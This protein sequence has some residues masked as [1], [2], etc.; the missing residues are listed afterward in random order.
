MP[1]PQETSGWVPCS[2]EETHWILGIKERWLTLHKVIQ[3]EIQSTQP[4]KYIPLPT[5]PERSPFWKCSRQQ[6]W[7]ED[8]P[9]RRCCR[10]RTCCLQLCPEAEREAFKLPHPTHI[11]GF[12]IKTSSAS[13]PARMLCLC[14]HW[15]VG[16]VCLSAGLHKNYKTDFQETWWRNGTRKEPMKSQCGSGTFFFHL[17]V[18]SG[19][20]GLG[21]CICRLFRGSSSD[22]CQ[23]FFFCTLKG[24]VD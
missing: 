24:P 3:L 8:I 18:S 16:S 2:T 20:W 6:M 9:L 17:Q 23:I 10:S 19:F 22:L 4:Q 1:L 21:G 12:P 14:I 5:Y 7:T 15:S 11:T 13:S